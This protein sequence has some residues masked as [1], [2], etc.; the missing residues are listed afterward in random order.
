MRLSGRRP[1]DPEKQPKYLFRLAK[2]EQ[3]SKSCSSHRTSQRAPPKRKSMKY[4]IVYKENS[5]I[6]SIS[7]Y[8]IRERITIT[9]SQLSTH[10]SIIE[11]KLSRVLIRY[12]D[13]TEWIDFLE[14]MKLDLSP[15]IESLLEDMSI[16]NGGTLKG[17]TSEWNDHWGVWLSTD[18]D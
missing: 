7:E 1:S 3:L 14:W 13:W 4:K 11:P 16:K 10:I 6:V 8:P 18:S 12:K 17:L 9:F 15:Y 5:I 2:K